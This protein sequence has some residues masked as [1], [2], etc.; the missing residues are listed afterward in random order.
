MKKI[1][2]IGFNRVPRARVSREYWK[3]GKQK[4]TVTCKN[5]GESGI[6]SQAQI[7]KYHSNGYVCYACAKKGRDEILE[8]R[9][10][11]AKRKV[12]MREKNT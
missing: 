2:E 3:A 4:V 8:A 5:C 7:K 1:G 6:Q 9:L 11:L 10:A 12:E